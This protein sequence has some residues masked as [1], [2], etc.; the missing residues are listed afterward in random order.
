MARTR[1]SIIRTWSING[2]TMNRP[3]P[4]M[5]LNLPSR[6]ITPFSHWA[7]S[8][9]ADAMIQSAVSQAIAMRVAHSGLC[10]HPGRI[11]KPPASNRMTK[12]RPEM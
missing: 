7:A 1:V 10:S 4:L 11:K 5:L 9:T 12:I 2:M 8:R 3:G 6:K